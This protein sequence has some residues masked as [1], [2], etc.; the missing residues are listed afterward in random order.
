LSELKHTYLT[1]KT[2]GFGVIKEKSSKFI[3][4]AQ[5]C[6]KLSEVNDILNDLKKEHPQASHFCYAYSLGTQ[7]KQT[8]VNDDGEPSNSA[9]TPILG[10]INSLNLSN[11][12]VVVIRYYGGVKLGVGGLVQAYKNAAKEALVDAE[13]A[14]IELGDY[15]MLQF[16]YEKLV[17]LMNY[18]KRRKINIEHNQINTSC[19]VRIYLP[20]SKS[21]SVLEDLINM[22][23]IEI[24]KLTI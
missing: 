20:L 15:Y 14:E 7:N 24:D 22:H 3:G 5:F 21:Q 18:L 13:I 19:S 12:L 4:V 17:E 16:S 9:G 10:Q 8:R 2:S 6:S 23:G 11:V 1:I